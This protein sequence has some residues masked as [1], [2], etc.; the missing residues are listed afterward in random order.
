MKTETSA[1]LRPQTTRRYLH[2]PKAERMYTL[3]KE[4]KLIFGEVVQGIDWRSYPTLECSGMWL[5]HGKDDAQLDFRQ[6]EN[7]IPENGVPFHGLTFRLG[8][9]KLELDAFCDISR[10]PTCF[11]TL[12][13]SNTGAEP[14]CEP[15][16]LLLRS[17]KEKKLV[18]ATPDEYASYAPDVNVWKEAPATWHLLSSGERSVVADEHVFLTAEGLP[19]E[20][21]EDSGAL[22]FM[23]E[24]APGAS[25]AL[26]LSF[27]KGEPARFDIEQERALALAFWERELSRL[28]R[29]PDGIKNDPARLKMAQNLSVQLMQCFC[30]PVGKNY[31]LS[32]Q[33]G[34]QRLIWPWEAISGLEA[35]GRLGDFSDYIEPV[36]S[37]YF[38]VLQAP[39]GEIR[40]A[41]EGWACITASVLYSFARYCLDSRAGFY[42]RYRDNAM[43]A[44]DWIVRTRRLSAGMEGCDPGLFPPKRGCDW[45]QE[46]QAWM[47]TDIVNADCL[48]KFAE[49]AER[50]GDA[51]AAEVR[52]EFDD[53]FAALRRTMKKF[54]DEAEGSD[55]L[56]IPLCPDGDDAQ[57][58]RE[59]YPY[60]NFGKFTALGVVR[61]ED[62]ERV[63]NFV[64]SKGI[65][66]NG[67]YGHMP[68]SDGNMH[69]WY[70]S[71]PDYYWFL[72]W[73]RLGQREL[74]EDILRCQI[75]YSMTDEYYMIERYADNDPYYVPWSPNASASGRTLIMM[76]DLYA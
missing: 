48:K 76:L 72:T 25:A 63:L 39:D 61:D 70:T 57:L 10:T 60:F 30:Y 73:M 56:R 66:G 54:E 55:K 20:W 45:G 65:F 42:D 62:V 1:W 15:L 26:T 12:K 53:Y 21:G 44:F 4:G 52:A 18:F 16:A 32:R 34:M 24:L 75:S 64:K 33:G 68:Y 7:R 19:T 43:A 14:L 13:L 5:V 27:G 69:I 40:P 71:I 37:M 58:L 49:A 47:T 51:R 9:L 17:G 74:A 36:L 41:G 67:L 31:L 8:A 6:A 23:A 3:W 50:F 46:Y 11:V 22:R 59:F 2:P 35:L 28:N 29:L 38:D